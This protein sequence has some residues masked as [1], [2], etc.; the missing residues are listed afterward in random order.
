M[1]FFV[2]SAGAAGDGAGESDESRIP[3]N[4]QFDQLASRVSP[5]VVA[6]ALMGLVLVVLV[7]VVP[8]LVVSVLVAPTEA[9]E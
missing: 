7:L 2:N 5:A 6:R 1:V 3:L 9:S 8:V 4:W